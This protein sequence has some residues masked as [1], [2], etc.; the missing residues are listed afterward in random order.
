MIEKMNYESLMNFG[1]DQ[2]GNKVKVYVTSGVDGVGALVK[3]QVTCEFYD[4]SFDLR[5][6][7]LNNKNFRL[8]IPEL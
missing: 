5:I 4:K 7:G 8:K 2:T 6:Q 3:A 1:W